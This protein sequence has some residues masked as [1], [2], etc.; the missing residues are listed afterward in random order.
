MRFSVPVVGGLALLTTLAACAA[1]AG[2]TGAGDDSPYN[3]TEIGGTFELP[4]ITL[5]DTSGED[6]NLREDSAGSTTAVF[7]GFTNCPDICPTTMADMAQAVQLLEPE[8]REGVDVVFV[9]ADPDRDDT[10][11]LRMWL[12]S[13]DSS[14][15]GL[16]GETAD[17]DSAAEELA[18]SIER[19]EDRT[20]NYQVGHG[21][22]TLVFSPEGESELM[23]RYG[24]E[25]DAIAEDLRLLLEEA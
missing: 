6:Y 22:Q 7:F 18:V 11:V 13:F 10:E 15:T 9:T 4:D 17:I 2:P 19:P 21:S 12:D 20:G 16:T 24:T 8:Q 5:T 25:P 14:F 1:P 23:W 3:G